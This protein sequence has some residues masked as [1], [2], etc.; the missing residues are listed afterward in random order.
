[1]DD[2]GSLSTRR[3]YQWV[4]F[5]AL[6]VAVACAM[7]TFACGGSNNAASNSTQYRV[8]AVLSGPISDGGWNAA[9][10][11]GL[12]NLKNKYGMQVAYTENAVAA[13]FES[14]IQG[15]AQQG[16]NLVIGD[17]SEYA[18]PIQKLA[19]QFPNTKFAVVFAGVQAANVQSFV[20]KGNEIGYLQGVVAGSLTKTGK[21]GWVGG[22]EIPS[23]KEMQAGLKDGAHASNPS[24]S[25]LVA[26]TGSFIDVA[27]GQEAAAGLTSQG[28][29]VLLAVADGGNV[30]V[31]HQAGQAGAKFV[32]WPG[33]QR[34]LAP[35]AVAVSVIFN[36]PA[37]F[38]TMGTSA[39][40]NHFGN[41]VTR[42]GVSDGILSYGP[43]ASWVPSSVVDSANKVYASMKDG[44]FKAPEHPEVY[45]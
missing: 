37:M 10:Y 39:R 24:S 4:R 3:R 34:S 9:A 35:D 42:L 15:Y 12:Q 8:A 30:G 21:I 41:A 13:N 22:I 32:G 6:L 2:L 31:I 27:K 17:G 18:T 44:S 1:M 29:D 23:L 38:E 20:P 26:Y 5:G 7:V 25:V 19:P 16:F 14:I 33:D 40:D 36:I 28:A 45:A 43:F 11:Q